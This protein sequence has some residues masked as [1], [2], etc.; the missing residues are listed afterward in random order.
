MTQ[1]GSAENTWASGH[2]GG[3]GGL[4]KAGFSG[5]GSG[6]AGAGEGS[7]SLSAEGAAG[8]TS[9][10]DIG[11]STVPEPAAVRKPELE[12]VVL[13]CRSTQ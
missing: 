11:V 8:W 1:S 3:A 9:W 7:N 2:G 13:L 6:V 10:V 5:A 4:G 12:L